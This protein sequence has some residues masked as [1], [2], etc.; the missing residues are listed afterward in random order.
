MKG[1]VWLVGAGPGDL[2]LFTIKGKEILKRAEVVVYDRLVGD[3][4]LS[5]IPQNAKQVDA[6]K[7]AGTH[8]MAQEQINQTLLK[9]AQ[10]GKRVV[11]LKGGDPFLFGR[12]GEELEL[13]AKEGIPFEVVPG[14]T[15][16][17]AVPAYC[18]IPV[19]HREYASSVHVI[20]GHKKKDEPLQLDFEALVRLS[21]TLVFL[22]GVSALSDICQGLLAAGMDPKMPAAVL[23]QGTKAGQKKILS[24][25]EHLPIEVKRQGVETPAIVLVGKVCTLGNEFEWY[26]RLPLFGNKILVTRPKGRSGT[27]SAKLRSLG[28]EVLELPAIRT[29]CIPDHRRLWEEFARLSDY[30]YLVF[31]SPAGVCQF[32]DKLR[33]AGKDIRSLGTAKLCA[34]GPGTRQELAARGLLCDHMPEVYDGAHL[35]ILLGKVCREK[36]KILIPRAEKGKPQLIEEIQKRVDV[37]ITDLPIYQTIYENPSEWMDEKSQIE[38]GKISMAVFTSASTVHGFA[39][40][41]EGLDYSLVHAVCIGVQTEAA[42]KKLGMRTVVSEK[43]TI[44]SLVDACVKMAQSDIWFRRQNVWN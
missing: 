42:A 27:I 21:G 29:E 5:L 3:S 34:I 43:A 38:N 25:L 4:I 16:A 19:T 20:T 6:G 7:C 40:A 2:G 39:E 31:T 8:T 10:Q 33:Q 11:R 30:Q 17:F 12:G 41:T 37:E 22:M 44:D 18:G 9:E 32:F 35:G 13:L 23:Q 14:V 36:D 24:D 28:A 1:K 26:E 15:S